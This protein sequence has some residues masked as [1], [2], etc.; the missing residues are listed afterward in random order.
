LNHD[1]L[2]HGEA[3]RKSLD[4]AVSWIEREDLKRIDEPS[5]EPALNWDRRLTLPLL[6]CEAEAQIKERRP[7]YLPANVFQEDTPPGQPRSSADP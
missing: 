6:C 2:G 7:L 1:R 4:L 3:A 5:R